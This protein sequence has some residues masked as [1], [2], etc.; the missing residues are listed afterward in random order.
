MGTPGL[1]AAVMAPRHLPGDA[2]R[3]K[4]LTVFVTLQVLPENAERFKEIHRPLWKK[5]SE[6]DECL[7]FDVFQDPETPGR[8]RFV[9]VWRQGRQWFEE[10]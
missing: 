6:E 7:L 9:E 1:N 3:P 10:V 4:Q 2:A 5:C 8:F